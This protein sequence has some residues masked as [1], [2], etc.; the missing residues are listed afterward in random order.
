MLDADRAVCCAKGYYPFLCRKGF[1]II[2]VRRSAVLMQ[3]QR[4]DPHARKCINF[5]VAIVFLFLP[6]AAI[7]THS[8][9]RIFRPAQAPGLLYF[10]CIASIARRR[11]GSRVHD[12]WNT[13]G[14][15]GDSPICEG[16]GGLSVRS[17]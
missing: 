4:A 15:H 12:G 5:G 16:P 11:S 13:G 9:L 2:L 17:G 8:L 10:L 3:V 1:R 14:S 6:G 7:P